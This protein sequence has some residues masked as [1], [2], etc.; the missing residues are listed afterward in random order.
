MI[1]PVALLKKYNDAL[2]AFDLAGVEKMFAED[3]VYNSPGLKGEVRGRDHIM[4]AMREYF[5]EFDDQI[6][7]DESIE[8]IDPVT[9]QSIWHLRATSSKTGDKLVR[10]G[11]GLIRFNS[12]GLIARVEV[13]DHV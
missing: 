5:L 2:N 11:V 9:A 12:N 13:S 4:R 7:T 10:S 8:A 3:A 1:D 6:S